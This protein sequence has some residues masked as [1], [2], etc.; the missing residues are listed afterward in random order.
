M[1]HTILTRSARTDERQLK[2]NAAAR[3]LLEHIIQ[4]PPA[5]GA[6][7]ADEVCTL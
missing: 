7:T 2:P 4:T 1:K 3:D 5:L 6:L